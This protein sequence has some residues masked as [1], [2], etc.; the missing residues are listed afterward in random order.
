MDFE[1]SEEEQAIRDLTDQILADKSTHERL[2]DLEA[3]SDI[4]DSEAWQALAESGVVGGSIPEGHGGAGLGFMAAAK[5]VEVAAFHASPVPL[6]ST[7]VSV[8]LPIAEFGTQ[9]QQ[10]RWLPPIAAGSLLAAF[11]LHETGAAPGQPTTSATPTSGG[12]SI[13]GVKDMVEGGLDAPLL[14]VP[15]GLPDG[16][17]GVFLVPVDADGISIE[18]VEVTSG[19]SQARVAF[20]S[21]VVDDSA[22]L[23][24]G[25]IDGSKIVEWTAQRV[26]VAMCMQMAGAARASIELAADYTKQRFQFDRAIATFQAVSNRAGDTYIDTEAIRL[27]A[28]QAAWRLDQGLEAANEIDIAKWWAAEAGFRV[29]H[30]AVHVH[31]GVGVDR[32]YP[33]HRHFLLARQLELSL[34]TGEEHLASLGR[35]IAAG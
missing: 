30:G 23:G 10:S 19:R 21:V 15:A 16:E 26:T 7:V 25:V 12:W 11:A 32:D 14:L 8:A 22:L 28:Y 18:P 4:V 1:L 29:V 24:G 34:G 35:S 3:S 31:G 20:D 17:V 27:T 9:E 33:L 5:S 13:T 6:V 2:R